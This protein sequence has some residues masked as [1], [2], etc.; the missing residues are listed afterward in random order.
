MVQKDKSDQAGEE[1]KNN[2]CCG[3]SQHYV[4][5]MSDGRNV[6]T[7]NYE[8]PAFVVFPEKQANTHKKG[9]LD[10]DKEDSRY[11]EGAIS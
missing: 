4:Q 8:L 5:I 6:F 10:D 7:V 11:D 9:L 2:I 3:L 1:V